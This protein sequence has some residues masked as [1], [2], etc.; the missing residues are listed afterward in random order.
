MAKFEDISTSND[1]TWAPR[2]KLCRVKSGPGD[3]KICMLLL[4]VSEQ[5]YTRTFLA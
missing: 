5:V 3:I 1:T 2:P 4:T